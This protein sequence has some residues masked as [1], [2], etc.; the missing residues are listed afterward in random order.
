MKRI[1]I[2]GCGF[3]G[4]SAAA[5]L[6]GF[7][8][9]N[10]AIEIL[11]IDKSRY[12]SFLP[13]L[14][15]CLGRGVNP[16]FLSYDIEDFAKSK[17]C[18]LLNSQISAVDLEKKEVSA[19]GQ[20]FPYDYLL[21]SSGTETN[22]YGNDALQQSAYK[23]DS[24]DD[25]K[26]IREA[27]LS[28]SFG[29]YVISGGGYTGIEVATNLSLYLKK[30]SLHKRVVIVERAPEILGPLPGWMK[31][32]VRKNLKELNIEAFTDNAIK[33]VKAK[34]IFLASGVKFTNAMLIWTAGVRTA[35]YIQNL[36]VKKNPQGRIEVD[37]YLRLNETC[38]VAGDASLFKYQDNF[39][40]MSVQFAITQGRHAGLNIIRGILGKNLLAYKPKDPGYIIPLANNRACGKIF[41]KNMLGF[42]PIILHYLMCVYLVQGLKNKTGIIKNL[43]TGGD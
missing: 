2:L 8:R 31:D 9:Q 6:S 21:I 16:S 22:F 28:D 14:P 3:A 26:K 18:K 32:Y 38:F 30:K 1:I 15:D 19:S 23:L 13:M 35:A 33:E 39:L 36:G 34:E 27:L 40:R 17:N 25:A 5:H 12:S 43:T 24:I 29:T 42:L 10:K 41:G 20:A 37:E 4:L 11:V 7:A